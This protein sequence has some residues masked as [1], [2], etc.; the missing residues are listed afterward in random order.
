MCS[1]EPSVPPPD[2][3]AL[4]ISPPSP[5]SGQTAADTTGPDSTALSG[6]LVDAGLMLGQTCRVCWAPNGTLVIPGPDLHLPVLYS[7]WDT[8][9]AANVAVQMVITAYMH[10]SAWTRCE[11]SV[12]QYC[13]LR[14]VSPK[15]LSLIANRHRPTFHC[16]CPSE[17]DRERAL[18]SLTY[19]A[20]CLCIASRLLTA[21]FTFSWRAHPQSTIFWCSPTSCVTGRGPAQSAIAFKCLAHLPT[22]VFAKPEARASS[23]DQRLQLKQQEDQQRSDIQQALQL[24]LDNSS[25]DAPLTAGAVGTACASELLYS[26]P[27]HAVA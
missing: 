24:H 1:G 17:N 27:N 4:A 10:G 16:S 7:A 14:F 23:K 25:P 21:G 5:P 9:F 6:C 3:A 22:P 13:W 11:Q 12:S 15:G 2:A 19:T 18:K 20:V 26:V 8:Q